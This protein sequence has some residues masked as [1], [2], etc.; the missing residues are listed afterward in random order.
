MKLN[1]AGA[2]QRVLRVRATVPAEHS[3]ALLA[4]PALMLIYAKHGPQFMSHI[5][6]P[7]ETQFCFSKPTEI[8]K[9]TPFSIIHSEF[10]SFSA[11]ID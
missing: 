10:V 9:L 11:V 8:H 5:Q 1:Q 4:R 7:I 6:N 2:A 3:R